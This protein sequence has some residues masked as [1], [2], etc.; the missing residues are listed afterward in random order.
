MAMVGLQKEAL[1][2]GM[3]SLVTPQN[4]YNSAK[5]LVKLV[6]LKDVEPLL[7]R[8]DAPGDPQ[9]PPH[10]TAAAARSEE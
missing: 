5:E 9:N 4:L 7:H 1:A 10:R 6:D 3:T 8:P 2:G